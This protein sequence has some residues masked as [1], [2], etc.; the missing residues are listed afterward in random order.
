MITAVLLGG[1][2]FSGGSGH[3]L[4][5]FLGVVLIGAMVNGMA[6]YGLGASHRL[7]V[8]GLVLLIPLALEARRKVGFG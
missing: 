3:L 5:T 8:L 2:G 1:V 4:G 6:L 7:I